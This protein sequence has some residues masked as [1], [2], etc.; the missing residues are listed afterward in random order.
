[1]PRAYRTATVQA[2]YQAVN[3]DA[4]IAANYPQRQ[5]ILDDK[6]GAIKQLV[7]R[8]P[9]DFPQLVVRTGQTDGGEMFGIQNY[10]QARTGEVNDTTMRNAQIVMD[11]FYDGN[12]QNLV[13]DADRDAL[14][15]YA[16]AA[17]LDAGRKGIDAALAG[18]S[19]QRFQR[20]ETLP[21]QTR[22]WRSTITLTCTYELPPADVLP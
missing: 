10:G 6:T 20:A 15:M 17:V 9:A 2:I 18:M 5:M 21:N 11:F 22:V 4:W 13:S 16:L 8:A 14:E 12:P 7:F 19:Y 3:A 1:M